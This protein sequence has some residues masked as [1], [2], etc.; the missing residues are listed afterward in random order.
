VMVGAPSLPGGGAIEAGEI[1]TG[2]GSPW[3]TRASGVAGCASSGAGCGGAVASVPLV[4]GASPI[5]GPAGVSARL[6]ALAHAANATN[7]M[8]RISV[9][10]LTA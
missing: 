6:P 8:S 9:E 10:Y 3:A 4:G 7:Q 1:K 5:G 2:A